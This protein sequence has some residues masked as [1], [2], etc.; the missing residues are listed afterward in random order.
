MLPFNDLS[1]I[2]VTSYTG[3]KIFLHGSETH[4][5]TSIYITKKK[6]FIKIIKGPKTIRASPAF[7]LLHFPRNSNLNKE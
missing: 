6:T 1:K 3:C 4:T 7:S 2:G 5:D